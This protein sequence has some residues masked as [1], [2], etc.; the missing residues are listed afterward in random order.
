MRGVLPTVCLLA[1]AA[2]ASAPAALRVTE[3]Q[4]AYFFTDDDGAADVVTVSV[5]GEATVVTDS[6]RI[7]RAGPAWR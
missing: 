5:G 1:L 2:P 3:D 4:R 6:A 7:S